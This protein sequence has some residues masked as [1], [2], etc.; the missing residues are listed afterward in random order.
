MLDPLDY[1]NRPYL[2]ALA[3]RRRAAYLALLLENIGIF[4]W[5][6]FF[7][8]LFFAGLWMLE[9]PQF[10]GMAGRVIGL[11]VFIGGVLYFVKNDLSRFHLPRSPQIDKRIEKE[12]AILHGHIAALDDT[13]ANP[14]KAKARQLWQYF[15]Q[16]VLKTF[17]RLKS[18]RPRAMLSRKDP[19]ALRF[20]ALLFFISGLFVAGQDWPRRLFDGL[21]PL[22]PYTVLSSGQSMSLWITPPDYTGKGQI[23]LSGNGILKKPI[24]IPQ[25]SKIKLRV[26]SRLGGLFPPIFTMGGHSYP[27]KHLGDGIF[28]LERDIGQGDDMHVTQAIITRARWP[29]HFIKDTPPEIRFSYGE[30]DEPKDKNGDKNDNDNK[31]KQAPA[32]AD[33]S[34]ED[35][36]PKDDTKPPKEYEILKRAQLRFPL[37]VKDDYGVTNLRMHVSLDPV[38]EDK[39]LGKDFDEDKI[40]MS[41][42]GAEFKLDP[43]YD[44]AGS[45][46]AGLPVI[47]TFTAIDHKGQTAQTPPLSMTLPERTFEHPVAKSLIVMRKKLAWAYNGDFTTI[48]ND[49]DTLLSAPGF[50]QNNPVVFLAI[51]TAAVR[52]ALVNKRP[53]AE[54][55]EAARGVINLLWDTAIAV[56]D[57]DLTLAMRDLRDAQKALEQAMKDP[58]ATDDD[59]ARLMAQLQ[60][61]MANYFA[62]LQKEMQK[63][64]ANGEKIP[65]IPPDQ[66]S[67]VISP[68]TMAEMLDKLQSA[69][70]SGNKQAAQDMLSKLQRMM[71]MMDPSMTT[72]LP[73]DMQMMQEGVNELQELIEKQESLLKQTTEQANKQREKQRPRYAPPIIK[74]DMQSLRDLGME[75]L[76]PPPTETQKDSAQSSVINT[77]GNRAEQEGLRYVLGQIMM[78]AAEKLDKVPENM[79]KAEQEMRGSET[80]LTHNDPSGSVPHQE[81]AIKYLKEAQ[82]QLSKQLAARMQMMIGFSF[83]GAQRYDPL[84]RPYGRK[85]G[86]DQGS[87]VKV[88]DEGQK[89]RV[90]EILRLLRRRSGEFDRPE[91]ELEYF[92]RLLRQF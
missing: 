36:S 75:D 52:L 34:Q 70:R 72:M 61:K 43:V 24:D 33:R 54:R 46:W 59:I 77:Q 63:R 10:F 31:A 49:L 89:K 58:N 1:E 87:D 7:W 65:Q 92:R 19:N 13:I 53:Q 18:P 78:D 51:Q 69:M 55:T 47:I 68:E 6:L 91:D 32:D 40:V 27:L 83:N 73:P 60:E 85:K 37:I 86:L 44:L 11:L 79:G 88:P 14:Q 28:G 81:K 30:K 76:P 90:D 3:R 2:D 56:E 4:C 62:E 64:I 26:Q 41:P 21:I 57:G 66:F 16:Q 84:G 23:Y 9:I 15:G 22:T 74:P 82:K 38:V 80:A 35:T 50:F 5:R 17:T 29:Y 8:F 48:S 25:D 67:T 39:P 71:D 45:T 42:P 20:L 12:S